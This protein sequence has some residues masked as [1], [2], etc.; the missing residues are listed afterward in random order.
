[1]ICSGCDKEFIRKH[2]AQRYCCRK[3]SN[4]YARRRMNA[5]RAN[6]KCLQ[7]G[8]KRDSHLVRC[9]KCQKYKLRMARKRSREIKKEFIRVYGGKCECCSENRWEFL[10]LDHVQGGGRKDSHLNRNTMYK[11]AMENHDKST[12]RLLCMNCNTAIGFYGYCPHHKE[13]I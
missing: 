7:C 6:S 8:K 1:M 10:S 9:S 5:K 11:I 13:K 4:K 12:Y 3:C 2:N